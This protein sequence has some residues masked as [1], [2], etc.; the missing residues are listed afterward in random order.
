MHHIP[1]RRTDGIDEFIRKIYLVMFDVV[2]VSPGYDNVRDI[3]RDLK[4]S[5]CFLDGELE[6]R[7]YGYANFEAFITSEHMQGLVDV[8]YRDGQPVYFRVIPK[9]GDRTHFDTLTHSRRVA[10]RK[11][12]RSQSVGARPARSGVVSDPRLLRSLHR[13]PQE[14]TGR[15]LQREPP[16]Q[17]RARSQA[18]PAHRAPLTVENDPWSYSEE[19]D[20]ET[21][22][23]NAP[24][25]LTR[26]GTIAAQRQRDAVQTSNG[27]NGPQQ[28]SAAPQVQNV[29]VAPQRPAAPQMPRDNAASVRPAASQMQ[30][31]NAASVRPAAP[32]MQRN[33]T[34][35]VR[36]A[37]PQM[38]RVNTSSVRPAAPQMQGNGTSTV[39]SA[40][41]QMPR[42]GMF[43]VRRAASLMQR[44]ND[45]SAT[46]AAPQTQRNGTSSVRPTAPRVNANG[47][48]QR[49]NAPLSNGSNIT[50][51]RS[52][53]P[54]DPHP[55][56][57]GEQQENWRVVLEPEKYPNVYLPS[58]DT[59]LPD[60]PIPEISPNRAEVWI[61]L[62][63]RLIVSAWRARP[64]TLQLAQLHAD[65]LVEDP[66]RISSFLRHT[67]DD[68]LK[69]FID[70][71][72][73]M[74]RVFKLGPEYHVL[75]NSEYEREHPNWAE[76]F[77]RNA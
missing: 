8:E 18:A 10:E 28:R 15:T 56:R 52:A 38:Q 73:P 40:A 19:D 46:S 62:R 12:A 47:Q 1:L 27:G 25:I 75:W 64:S 70:L 6:A 67:Y 66:L 65:V 14:H 16:P 2:G 37:A 61:Y 72:L 48:P 76:E 51:L 43:S 31:V 3:L 74:L 36:P 22:F 77:M 41:P 59:D 50:Q 32:Q 39:R 60:P 34:S 57:G 68:D 5:L 7:R 20:D 4:G 63:H 24:P 55:T 45:P 58:D 13:R 29:D 30:R 42:N 35:S 9:E 11:R 23:E 53:A 33:G 71:H 54:Q 69:S 17:A 26:S 44:D 49:P 21:G